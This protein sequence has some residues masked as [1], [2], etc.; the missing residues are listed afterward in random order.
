M[1]NVRLIILFFFMS[2]GLLYAQEQSV[3]ANGNWYKIGVTKSGIYK[4]DRSLIDRLGLNP[5]QVNPNQ[6]KVYGNGGNM[7]PQNTS[8]F[9]FE[10]LYEND[11]M[12][13]G[14]GSS[15]GAN[16]LLLFYG[17]GPEQFYFDELLDEYTYERN[18]YSDTVYYFLQIDGSNGRNIQTQT[19]LPSSANRI[20]T[21]EALAAHEV[22][23]FNLLISGRHWFGESFEINRQQTFSFE[24]SIAN[25]GQTKI[26]VQAMSTNQSKLTVSVNSNAVG[27]LEFPATS[28]GTYALKG[29]IVRQEFVLNQANISNREALR[30]ELGFIEEAQPARAYLDYIFI[31]ADKPLRYNNAAFSFRK[32]ASAAIA[33]TYTVSNVSDNFIVWDISNPL[34]PKRQEYS[35][36]GSTA[37]FSLNA[38]F[39]R[40]FI[41]FEVKDA[42]S[43][44]PFGQVNNQ[45]IKALSVPDLLI[46]THP[47]FRVEAKR[48]AAHREAYSGYKVHVVS[49]QEVYNEFAS[50]KADLTAIRD[51]A[52][53][54]H[55]RDSVKF[56]YLLL[57]GAGSY[58]YKHRLI[59]GGNFVPTYQSRESLDPITTYASDDYFGFLRDDVGR[60]AEGIP[61]TDAHLM[62]I[63]VGRLPA[64]ST[65]EARNMVDK[66]VNYEIQAQSKGRWRNRITFVGDDGDNN[67][68]Q[69]NS[70]ELARIVNDNYDQFNIN[71]IYIDAYEQIPRANGKISPDVNKALL[72]DIDAGT[73]M[74]NFIG[75]GNED[76][77]TEER[78]FTSSAIENMNN[79]HRLPLFVTATCEFGRHD[80]PN[81]TSGAE[82]L[83]IS[84]DKGAIA[85]LTTSRPV[86]N[87]TNQVLNRAFFRAV[88]EKENG[89]YPTLGE[90]LKNTKNNAIQGV[91]NRNFILLGDPSMRLAYPSQEVRIEEVLSSVNH[92]PLDTLK[93]LQEVVLKGV[94]LKEDGTVNSSFSGE[95][96]AEVFDKA[97][98]RQTLGY[99]TNP[100][101]FALYDN[102]IH[103]GKASVTNGAFEMVFRVS[104]NIRYDYGQGRISLYAVNDDA[105]EDAAGAM[106]SVVFG[107]SEPSGVAV[108]KP[109]IELYINDTTFNS[110]G[111]VN[112]EPSLIAKLADEVG[113]NI[114]KQTIERDI[115]AE[116]IGEQYAE[117]FQLNDYYQ[118]DK[119]TYKSG[120]LEFPMGKLPKGNYQLKLSAWNN[121]NNYSEA[122]IE[123]IVTDT[124]ELII[125]NLLFYPNPAK[126]DTNIKFKHNRGGEPIN[127]QMQ[128][129]SLRGML[130]YSFEE[131]FDQATSEIQPFSWDLR[132]NNGNKL[133]EGMYLMKVNIRS[134]KDG[135]KNSA[136]QKLIVIN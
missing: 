66:I 112:N 131:S 77:W 130:V 23:Q 65:D 45:N 121:N 69:N 12:R 39:L 43:V 70:E 132:D 6:V 49:T 40:E 106:R 64:K 109:V 116:V 36:E 3:L 81:Y 120:V 2:C 18:P 102:V 114:S 82:K 52:R 21:Y 74:I 123:F 14:S 136:S 86:W 38:G 124:T 125:E 68:H 110:G 134:L 9:R 76:G 119:D 42:M 1:L 105:S 15:F 33:T 11:R 71:K 133:E 111:R 50:G 99:S 67:A 24:G 122:E 37:E 25:T 19:S 108:S 34:R 97:S 58:D 88:F 4:I 54:F 93:S 91:L 26:K 98:D 48:L 20:T 53:Y 84:K 72:D 44:V 35:R 90:V 89:Q 22:D 63:G 94:V 78:I 60:W 10:D 115:L 85:M 128:V 92:T 104:K 80:N 103:R 41:G 83:L 16:D 55:K 59:N 56:K 95:L 101:N 32:T 13:L 46:I 27:V 30:V 113:I 127:I 51:V 73:L 96:E 118:T 8:E 75:H 126:Y 117:R 17:Q 47:E 87:T 7:L 135:A 61:E 100:M 31:Q 28:P 129:F 79:P 5:D 107:G 62:D 29:N 57:F